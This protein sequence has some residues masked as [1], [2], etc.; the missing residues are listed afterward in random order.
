MEVYF[1]TPLPNL[2]SKI[3][4]KYLQHIGLRCLRRGCITFRG[5]CTLVPVDVL[6]SLLCASI[7]S[8]LYEVNKVTAI[9]D[10]TPQIGK[11]APTTPHTYETRQ[12][13]DHRSRLKP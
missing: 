11:E 7:A 8:R 12:N 5:H 10:E 1:P 9:I 13:G 3:Y 4:S 6:P 2:R